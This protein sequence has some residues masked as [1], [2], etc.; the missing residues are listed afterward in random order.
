MDEGLFDVLSHY[1]WIED[2]PEFFYLL[3]QPNTKVKVICDPLVVYRAETGVSHKPRSE[4]YLADAA[5]IN[6]TI[7]VRKIKSVNKYVNPFTYTKAIECG[8][9]KFNGW[10]VPERRKLLKDFKVTIRKEKAEA[11]D[12]I[13]EIINASK[14]Y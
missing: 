14:E 6:N 5:Q 2:V 10:I 9:N 12:Y 1:K 11:G 7:H 3:S 13:R 4:E 8:I